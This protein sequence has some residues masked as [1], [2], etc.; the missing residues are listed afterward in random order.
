[1]TPT[2]EEHVRSN[3]DRNFRD[4]IKLSEYSCKVEFVISV[5]RRTFEYG[6]ATLASSSGESRE[7]HLAEEVVS[8]HVPSAVAG[9]G[10]WPSASGR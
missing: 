10:G 4:D 1:M 5:N 2:V 9:S 6:G 3:V 8:T 7:I